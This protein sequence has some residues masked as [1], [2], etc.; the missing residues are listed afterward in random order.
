MSHYSV[1]VAI[2]SDTMEGYAGHIGFGCI[3]GI[4][5]Y[6]LAP[7]QE[8]PEDDCFLTF[9]D[10]TQE[11]QE[12]YQERTID[13][14]QFPDGS[15]CSIYDSKFDGKYMVKDGKIYSKPKVFLDDPVETEGS[16]ALILL[17]QQLIKEHYSFEEYC[18]DFC[19]YKL[20]NGRWGY[21]HNPNAKWDWWAVGGRWSGSMLAKQDLEDALYPREHSDDLKSLGDYRPIDGAFKKDIAFMKMLELEKESAAVRF[22]KLE[23]AFEQNDTSDLGPLTVIKEDGIYSWGDLAYQAGETLDEFL[24]RKGL[25]EDSTG[26]FYPYAVVDLE[27]DWHSEGDMGW[28]GLSSNDKPETDWHTEVQQFIDSLDDD[29]Y[30]I[31]VDCHI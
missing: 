5:D 26:G 18:S 10:C 16:K 12:K 22:F 25:D 2:P 24:H 19:G 1:L 4:L 14:V 3:D 20:E 13:F 17:P 7:Y 31:C 9:Q 21:W 29:D 15:V 28:F 11:C 30:L 6:L 8:S 27:G 23:K